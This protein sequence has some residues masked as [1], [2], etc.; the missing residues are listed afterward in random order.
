[1]CTRADQRR[2]GPVLN[3]GVPLCRSGM[4]KRLSCNDFLTSM[5]SG[6]V[7]RTA[8]RGHKH[9]ALAVFLAGAGPAPKAAPEDLPTAVATALSCCASTGTAGL[10]ASPGVQ[11]ACLPLWTLPSGA[12]SGETT[13]PLMDEAEARSTTGVR[14]LQG[15][16][17]VA[18]VTQAIVASVEFAVSDPISG[19][20]SC[21]I[22]TL[23]MQAASPRGH[24]FLPSY[25]VLTFCNGS[26]QLLLGLELA[27]AS[28][29][30]HLGTALSA[31]AAGLVAFASPLLMFSGLAVAWHLHCELQGLTAGAARGPS[32]PLRPQVEA[33]V[34]GG[35]GDEAPPL[36]R[37]F[38]GE[39]HRLGSSE[40]K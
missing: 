32:A 38:A 16:L 34:A 3:G 12:A 6:C 18:S 20:I 19:L 2:M 35:S 26:M 28:H 21:G 33:E 40:E 9:H 27:A 11:V 25:I 36:W 15:A 22:A 1:M 24:R 29:T 7:R 37:P 13:G 8:L 4:Q 31:K 14:R 30:W 39:S 17:V 5:G 23:G 10:L